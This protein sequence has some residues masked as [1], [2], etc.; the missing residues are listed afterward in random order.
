MRH[1]NSFS[2][3]LYNL[4]KDKQISYEE[5]AFLINVSTRTVYNYLSGIKFPKIE[6]LIRIADVL[7]ISLDRLFET[8]SSNQD[9]LL[10]DLQRKEY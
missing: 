1:K 6:T 9:D 5:F 2:L 7:K 3:N 8:N 4:L 10:K